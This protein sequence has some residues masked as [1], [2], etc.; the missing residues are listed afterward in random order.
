LALNHPTV[1]R[2]ARL[3]RL[4][5]GCRAR[6]AFRFSWGWTDPPERLWPILLRIQLLGL[7]PPLRRCIQDDSIHSGGAFTSITAYPFDGQEL[8]CPRACEQ[9]LQTPH[10][11]PAACFECLHDAG[12]QSA[13]V[14]LD[15]VPV[16]TGPRVCHALAAIPICT[17]SSP[18]T[19]SSLSTPCR[20]ST[21]SR[22]WWGWP[23]SSAGSSISTPLSVPSECSAPSW[24]CCSSA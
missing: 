11:V 15:G 3:G 24:R 19:A 18:T 23:C 12:L 21:P 17:G 8:G 22:R 20:A 7:S 2:P 4:A 1:P 6:G 10:T 5:L 16:E 13:D 14:A 9:A